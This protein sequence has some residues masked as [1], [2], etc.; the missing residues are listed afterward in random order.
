MN[1]DLPETGNPGTFPGL[2]SRKLKAVLCGRVGVA[3]VATAAVE[4]RLVDKNRLLKLEAQ[5]A[6]WLDDRLHIAEKS[7]DSVN[8]RQ[9]TTRRSTHSQRLLTSTAPDCRSVAASRTAKKQSKRTPS[10]P[11]LRRNSVRGVDDAKRADRPAAAHRSG[12]SGRPRKT[13]RQGDAQYR[14]AQH[15]RPEQAPARRL[16]DRP[17]HRRPA[18]TLRPLRPARQI[19][20]RPRQLGRRSHPPLQPFRK[21]HRVRQARP[22]RSAPVSAR[23][24]AAAAGQASSK[25]GQAC[26]A[27]RTR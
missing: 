16:P 17:R 23:P 3:T 9:S 8:L 10:T 22:Q 11:G 27:S 2:I 24:L 26:A 20:H 15:W 19:T 5:H 12:A 4:R 7:G 6:G 1:Y 18:A 25:Q 21:L 14:L 13:T